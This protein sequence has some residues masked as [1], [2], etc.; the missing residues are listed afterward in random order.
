MPPKTGALLRPTRAFVVRL[1]PRAVELARATEG[2]R[3]E[4]SG[5]DQKR[6]DFQTIGSE[7]IDLGS[8]TRL[9]VSVS[10]KGRIVEV[11]VAGKRCRFTLPEAPAGYVG[12][13]FRGRGYAAVSAVKLAK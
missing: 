4:D 2:K 13:Q 10:V 9:V 1:L 8:A 6:L 7:L 3:Q 11:E 5:S 12:F